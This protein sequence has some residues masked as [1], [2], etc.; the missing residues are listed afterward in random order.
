[1]R[2]EEYENNN[3]FLSYGECW[4]RLTELKNEQRWLRDV[5][6]TALVQSLRDQENAFQLFFKEVAGYPKFKAKYNYVQSYRTQN[7]N[8]SIRIDG[9]RIL[10]LK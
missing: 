7:I 8:N 6:S 5:D 2:K 3:S 9:N 1:M 10:C 4:G